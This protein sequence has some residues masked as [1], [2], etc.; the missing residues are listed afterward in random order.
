V[1]NLGLWAFELKGKLAW[2]TPLEANPIRVPE[3]EVVTHVPTAL[4]SSFPLLL[5]VFTSAIF[6]SFPPLVF[7]PGFLRLALDRLEKKGI[8]SFI[9]G[10]TNGS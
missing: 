4:L 7:S 10:V 1:A 6:P 3:H 2:T 9:G 8:V 5:Q